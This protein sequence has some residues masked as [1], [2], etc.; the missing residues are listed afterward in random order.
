[1]TSRPLRKCPTCRRALD[2]ATRLAMGLRTGEAL[3]ALCPGRTGPSDVD[4]I[5]HNAYITPERIA[6]L[7]YK[8][9]GALLSGGQAILRR[10]ARRLGPTSP[11]ADA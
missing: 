10:P 11:T 1:M 2:D 7:E 4:H 8:D 5:L 9:Q 3:N 6:F